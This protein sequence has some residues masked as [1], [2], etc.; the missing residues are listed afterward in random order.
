MNGS[1]TW[2]IL[3]A[4]GSGERLG[5][6]RPKAFIALGER[7]LLAESLE[8]LDASAWI[9]AV[10]VAV[11]PAWEEAAIVLAEELVASKVAAVVP[12]GVTRAASVRAALVEIPDDALVVIVHDA[13][14]PLI[15]DAMIERVL[16]PLAE[17]YDGVVPGLPL[18]DTVKRVERGL[19]VETLDRSALVAVQ[20]PQAFT[21]TALRSAYAGPDPAGATD[22]ASFVEARGGRI[23]VVA[24]DT[25]LLKITTG[26][27]LALVES[28]LGEP[29]P[30]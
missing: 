11:P 13:A 2:A 10:V 16:G 27:D 28:W 17:G 5:A 25:R 4:A 8:R 1:T 21:A 19:V 30:G 23:R 12:G 24:G 9:D 6:D 29:P 18:A 7:V 15:D 22:C 14:R 20:T 3:V 26:A